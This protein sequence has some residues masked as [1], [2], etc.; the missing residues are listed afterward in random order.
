MQTNTSEEILDAAATSWSQFTAMRVEDMHSMESHL[1]VSYPMSKIT[2][3]GFKCIL[4]KNKSDI[5]GQGPEEGRSYFLPCICLENLD[6][7]KDK[8]KFIR[9]LKK[10]PFMECITPCPFDKIV[11]YRNLCPDPYG[12][13]RLQE[14]INNMEL[15]T[16]KVW[17][18]RTTIGERRFISTPLGLKMIKY[19]FKRIN[20]RLPENL[21]LNNPTPHGFGR[22]L[23]ISTSVNSGTDPTI[24]AFTTK[25]KDPKTLKGYIKADD[26]TL[27][28]SALNV[29]KT[30]K[31]LKKN[32]LQAGFTVEIESSDEEWNE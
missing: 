24:V 5:T 6:E 9:Q 1:L 16:M 20:K 23:H 31:R 30:L 17:R 8:Q 14:R 13:I 29:A 15:P 22:G 28:R 12:N 25:H 32:N 18:A 11:K 10:Y 2:P 26:S 19:C 4:Q 7:D 3:R 21:K 27:C